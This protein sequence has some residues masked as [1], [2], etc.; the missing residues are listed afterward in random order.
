MIA[1]TA[2]AIAAQR[3]RAGGALGTAAG[4][5][6][7]ETRAAGI[8]DGER[9]AAAKLGSE[10]DAPLMARANSSAVAHRSRG[11]LLSARSIAPVISADRSG[12][13]WARRGGACLWRFVSTA[14]GEEPVNGAEPAKISY[15]ARP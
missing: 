10:A 11:C 3:H 14:M 4:V 7:V 15:A 13:R 2:A 12:R 9:T 6:T 1:T 8:D 5:T